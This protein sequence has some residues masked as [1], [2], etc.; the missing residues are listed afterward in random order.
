MY[1]C[2]YVCYVCMF[3][4][5]AVTCMYATYCKC[6]YVI[7]FVGDYETLGTNQWC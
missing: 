5:I 7:F 4:T 6:M 3:V 1:V 2:M